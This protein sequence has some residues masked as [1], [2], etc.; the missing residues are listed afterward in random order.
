MLAQLVP[1]EHTTT[2]LVSTVAKL[3]PLEDTT[4]KLAVRQ[5]AHIVVQENTTTKLAVRQRQLVG[6]SMTACVAPRALL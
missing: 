6:R 4:N 5:L 1:Q 2:K 3:V